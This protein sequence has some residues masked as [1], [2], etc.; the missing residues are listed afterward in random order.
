MAEP[1]LSACAGI[2]RR[3]DPDLF[4]AALFAP[5][6]ARERLMVL[7][8]FDITLSRATQAGTAETGPMLA[9]MRL[10]WWRDVLGAAGTETV[11]K[12]HE[13]AG[14]VIALIDGGHAPA[15]RLEALI[16]AREIELD[17]PIPEARFGEWA[18]ARFATLLRVS[19]AILAGPD[20]P[21]EAAAG[22]AGAVLATSFALRHGRRMAEQNIALLP[23]LEGEDLAALARGRETSVLRARIAE[24]AEAGLARLGEARAMRSAVPR[25]AIPAFLPLWRA[26]R[27]LD[28]ARRR[29]L[30]SLEGP[31]RG[32]ARRSLA[33]LWRALTARW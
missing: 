11:A 14:P 5:E 28:R 23:G 22:P 15:E 3:D 26:E 20:T 33:Y 4:A 29:G 25:K 24:M 9:A 21:A 18:E 12:S 32:D 30:P 8:A 13:V 1:S 2:V 16:A 17:S 10:Q 6:P 19:A 31:R 27:D 7:Y